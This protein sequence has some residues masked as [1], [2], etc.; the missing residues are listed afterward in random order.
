MLCGARHG[1]RHRL[2]FDPVSAFPHDAQLDAR[3]VA[4]EQRQAAVAVR[5]RVDL[6]PREPGAPAVQAE[7][8]LLDPAVA[9]RGRVERVREEQHASRGDH[10]ALAHGL[11]ARARGLHVSPP[12]RLRL[13]HAGLVPRSGR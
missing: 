1:P 4:R 11:G 13:E 10:A 6:R 8:E 5:R 9:M 12:R 7:L 3:R 2:E